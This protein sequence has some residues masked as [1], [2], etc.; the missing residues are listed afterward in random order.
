M[1]VPDS[2]VEAVCDALADPDCRRLLRALDEPLVAA[3]TAERCDLSRT[4]SYRKLTKLS[5]AGLVTEGLA[6]RRNGHHAA[7]FVRDSR[8]VV[9]T[10]SGEQSFEV[11][12]V[13]EDEDTPPTRAH[14]GGRSR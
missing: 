7:T 8:G 6:V 10:L 1:T 2:G 14:F 3:E 9:V 5:E 12:V 4:S 13:D 11:A